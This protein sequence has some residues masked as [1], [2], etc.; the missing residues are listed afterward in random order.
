MMA[1]YPY[2][3]LGI[4]LDRDFRN[5]LNANFDDIEADL[6]DIQ[7]NL[8]AKESR[9]AQIENDSIERDNDLDARIDNIVADAG[10]SNTEIVDARND[11]VNNV[12]YPTLKDRLDDTSDKIGIL[13]NRMKYTKNAT[14]P[15]VIPTYDGN[16]QTTHP[17]VLYFPN[18]WN[19]WVYWM[20]HT[21]YPLSDDDYENPC[22]SVSNDG[23]NWTDPV[24]ITNPIDQPTPQEIADG[25]HMS[26]THLVFNGNTLECWYRFNKNGVIDVIYRKTSTDGVNWSQREVMLTKTGDEKVLSPA[27]LFDENKYKMWYVNQNFKVFYIE[28]TDGFNWTTPQEVTVTFSDVSVG[29]RPWHLDVVKEG[30][31]YQLILNAG[32]SSKPFE[33]DRKSLFFGVSQN[34][35]TFTVKPIMFPTPPESGRWDNYM[36]YRASLVKVGN[37]YRL[38]YSAMSQSWEWSIGVSEGEDV[39][40]LQGMSLTHT[41]A[42]LIN[43]NDVKP[44]GDVITRVT[45]KYYTN[46]NKTSYIDNKEIKLVD[47]GVAG[48]GIKVTAPDKISIRADKDEDFG[49]LTARVLEAT[50]SITVNSLGQL[51]ND[52]LKLVNPNVAGARARVTDMAN[53]LDIFADNGTQYGYTRQ[54]GIQFTD[55]VPVPANIENGMVRWFSSEKKLK[56]YDKDFGVWFTLWPI[57]RGSTRPTT[58]LEPGMMWFDTTLNK[59]IWVNKDGNGWVD[60]NGN[61]V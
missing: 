46:E 9:L 49:D 55:G 18:A 48:A 51:K 45:R 21:P 60:A 19:G 36:L 5:N 7:S 42:D 54:A 1:R 11:S 32:E 33:N 47:P 58:N 27:I 52:E 31:Y 38:F 8:D 2:R 41:S 43:I 59:P 50:S 26:D 23:V 61:P 6:R 30:P 17:K 35:F 53:T 20:A 57:R 4:T 25:Y 13:N 12:T 40:N 16:N 29:Y 3:D 15:L 56:I 28:S 10:N 34:P 14:N 22:I 24:G 39:F 37:L 44:K